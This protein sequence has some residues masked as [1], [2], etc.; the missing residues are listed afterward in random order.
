MCATAGTASRAASFTRTRR[1]APR[2]STTRSSSAGTSSSRS[3]PTL[4]ISPVQRVIRLLEIGVGIGTDFI[5][6]ARA[7]ARATGVDL[8]EHAVEA[9]AASCGFRARGSVGRSR[10]GR[11][12][13]V[14]VC[15][16]QLS[17]ACIRGVFCTTPPIREGAVREAMRVIAPG[18]TI[19]VML[20]NRVSWVAFGL[21]GAA[22]APAR[23]SMV[24]ARARA[25]SPPREPGDEGVHAGRGSRD[26]RRPRQPAG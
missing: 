2:A 14:A 25:R 8:T 23:T 3:F 10:A 5:R 18:G 21:L 26:V 20:Y 19:T 24:V 16:R 7:G 22:R 1:K 13:A 9:R 6:F 17:T 12:G 15:R 4:P 11:R